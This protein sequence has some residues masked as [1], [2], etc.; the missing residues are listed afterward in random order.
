MSLDQ[1]VHL[2]QKTA[3]RILESYDPVEQVAERPVS[4]VLLKPGMKDAAS[5]YESQEQQGHGMSACMSQNRE[6]NR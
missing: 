1:M 4:N 5:Q 3:L 6:E 2:Y